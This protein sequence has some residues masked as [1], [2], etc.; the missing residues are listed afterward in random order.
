MILALLM[1]RNTLLLNVLDDYYT[2]II[3]VFGQTAQTPLWLHK[4]LLPNDL[5]DNGR[6]RIGVRG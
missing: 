4:T 2:T 3:V 5:R 6:M 1:L